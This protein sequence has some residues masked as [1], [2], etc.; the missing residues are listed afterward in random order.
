MAELEDG[1]AKKLLTG[2]K[3]NKQ[4]YKFIT[5]D[6]K[7][8]YSA[9]EIYFRWL[10]RLVILCA[11][12]SLSFFLCA[13][14][15]IFRLAP[16]II[17]EP[18]L[19]VQ[20][21]DSATMVRYEPITKNMP[22]LKQFTEMFVKQ[23]V[24]MRNTVIN[25]EQEMRTRW[26]PGGIM[27]YLSSP[28]VYADFVGVNIENIEAMFDNNYSSEVKIDEIGKESES[29]PAWY[30][31][32][33]VYSLSKNRGSAGALMLKTQRYKASVTPFYAAERALFRARLINPMGFVVIKYNQS[34][35][36]E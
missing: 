23:Y 18:L 24:I 32:F 31:V 22:S 2:K 4:Q 25:D 16:E 6:D 21:N 14:L 26:G 33:T 7:E 9:K 10:S 34:E 17:V 27:Q 13:S 15:V 11:L 28:E 29:S 5:Q 1:T 20:Q 35:I 36:R 19:I 30:V 8:V 3:Q 12:L